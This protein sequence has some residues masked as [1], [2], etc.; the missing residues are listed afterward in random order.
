MIPIEK[1][2]GIAVIMDTYDND[3][4][5][6]HP[7]ITVHYNEGNEEFQFADD[8]AS[9]YVGGCF[10]DYRNAEKTIIH[11]FIEDDIFNVCG[12]HVTICTA[13]F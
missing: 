11:L 1:W 13:P 5:D 10:A 9:T 6:P 7:F 12:L 3:G 2:N 8:G 4:A